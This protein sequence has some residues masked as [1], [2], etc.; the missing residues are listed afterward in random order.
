M[1]SKNAKYKA[2]TDK[3]RIEKV[4]KEGDQVMVFLRKERFP[5]KSYNKLKPKKYGPYSM[6]KRINDNA[7]VIELLDCM[8]ISHTFNVSNL[9]EHHAEKPLYSDNN[10][11]S[12]D[13]TTLTRLF[14]SFFP[15]LP[16]PIRPGA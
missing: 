8:N 10:L 3:H 2:D 15:S 13:T 6:V 1:E 4:F 9:F 11:R 5:I 16:T 12:L 7:Y 14:V